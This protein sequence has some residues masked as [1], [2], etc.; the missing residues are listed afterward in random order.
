MKKEQMESFC[1]REV[2]QRLRLYP[3]KIHRY[4]REL[5]SRYLIKRVGGNRKSGF[6]YQVHR[7]EEYRDLKQGL[8]VLDQIL[9]EL[10]A[11]RTGKKQAVSPALE[12]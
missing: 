9:S 1:S 10:R 11:G 4:L 7:W 2:Q 5:E 3:M 12:V 6:E 8:D